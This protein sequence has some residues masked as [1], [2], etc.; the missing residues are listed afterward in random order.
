MPS[1]TLFCQDLR[2]SLGARGGD[3]VQPI[4]VTRRGFIKPAMPQQS[5]FAEGRNCWRTARAQRVSFLID[6]AA[7]FAAFAA[8]AEQAQESIFI[9]G[10]DVDSRVCLVPD[11]M[12][13][14]QPME[15]GAFLK[16]IVSRRRGLQVYVLEWDF[17]VIFALE[18]ESTTVRQQRWRT[19]RRV[20]FR[21]DGAHP[22]GASHHQKVVVVDDAVAFVGGIDLTIRRWDNA[23]HRAQD[24]RRVDPA[25][26]F[27][28]P[29][30]DVQVAVDG[31]AARTLGQLV[32]ER[33]R[34]ATGCQLR[35]SQGG[36]SDAWPPGLSADLDH[37]SVA[38]ARTEPKYNGNAEV[39]EVEA[40]Y[41]DAIAAA[42]CSIYI[43][44]QYLTSAAIGNALANR[45]LQARGPEV[46]LVLPRKASGWLEQGTMDVL[47]AR[48]L[49]QLCA[50]DRFG[51]LRVYCPVVPDLDGACINLHSKVLIVDE[52]LVRIGSSNISNRSMGLDTECDIAVESA[53][54]A[55]IE[56]AIS[57]LR[58]R[59]LGEHLGVSAQKVAAT[60]DAKQSL[61]AT[62][63]G[64]HGR[65]RTLEP[66]HAEV[67]AWRDQ[68]IP[69]STILDPERP[70]V[71]E[72]LFEE[73]SA[74]K[75]WQSGSYAP[76]RGG[77]AL[78]ISIG[79]AAAWL[80]TPLGVWLDVDTLEESAT[81][82]RGHPIAPLVVIGGYVVGITA[83]IPV[84]VLITATALVFGPLLGFTYSLLGCLVSAM[85]TYGLGYLLGYETV[86]RLASAQLGRLSRRIAQYG[87][88]AILIVR[89]LP[90]T[91]FMALN[92]IA[93][94]AHIRL[95]DFVL[96]TLLGMLPGLLVFAIPSSEP[97]SSSS[98]WQR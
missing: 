63:E 31:E 58:N 81:S 79:L 17:A 8:A 94:A 28:P 65:G 20:Q 49:R 41:M 18:R 4:A 21:M 47:R 93:G 86:C 7:Y 42:Q 24:P 95:R 69:H 71:P 72:E 67:P 32:R 74:G 80:W 43:E 91:P 6:S 53:G 34:R 82:L 68:L 87:L 40:L 14:Q 25:G 75:S 37:I 56:R 11:G 90:V 89:I 85:L 64:L 35:A 48:L 61:I 9:I 10:W 73:C 16:A 1:S 76:L 59:L 38:I 55:I 12:R 29:V 46:V 70:L 96:G 3:A 2:V 52:R 44:S 51:R 33:W 97:F 60:L 78:L 66:L 39:R 88:L 57:R 83:L 54:S 15:L 62:V 98:G 30:H 19:H 77:I 92:V 26:Q 36:K 5:L 23:E 50:A 84:T 45:L 13:E 27:Y 22:A